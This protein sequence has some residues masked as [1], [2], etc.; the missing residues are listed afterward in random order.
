MLNSTLIL[1]GGM[2]SRLGIEGPKALL[3]FTP[4]EKKTLL[5]Y[6]I[7]HCVA[8]D[9]NCFIG[10]VTSK[11]HLPL[12]QKHLEAGLYF[13]LKKEHVTFLI[14]NEEHYLYNGEPFFSEDGVDATAP[15][16]NGG[17]FDCP[18][19]PTFLN[20]ASDQ[21]T[22][23][24]ID[25]PFID[26]LAPHFKEQEDKE[27]LIAVF[28]KEENEHDIGTV[29]EEGDIVDYTEE[30]NTHPYGNL[31]A[32]RFSK[33]FLTKLCETNPLPIHEVIKKTLHFDPVSQEKVVVEALKKEKF[34]TDVAKESA[35]KGIAFFDRE[36]AFGPIKSQEDIALRQH[37]LLSQDKELLLQA[38]LR[39]NGDCELHPALRIL[40][41]SQLNSTL[42]PNEP[43]SGYYDLKIS[44]EQDMDKA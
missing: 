6:K 20:T 14:Q 7:E 33:S 21:I 41:P 29:S 30:K 40:S 15:N 25:N 35:S 19:L 10:I 31:G 16:G 4:I 11:S 44:V 9:Q 24:S 8:R 28:Q 27:L 3:P 1:A 43:L 18:E 12:L 32:Y 37:Q 39:V 17:I 38:E 26:P 42:R 23:T 2:G 22:V 5:Q 34:I 13:G 36:T